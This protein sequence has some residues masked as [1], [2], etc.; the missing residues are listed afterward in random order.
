V[1]CELCDVV[2]EAYEATG[3]RPELV[4]GAPLDQLERPNSTKPGWLAYRMAAQLL[5]Y[6]LYMA[7]T[8]A[9]R[10]ALH[11]EWGRWMT[12]LLQLETDAG[13]VKDRPRQNFYLAPLLKHLTKTYGPLP[14]VN[15][16]RDAWFLK[17][18]G[19]A[20]LRSAEESRIM[21]SIPA[22]RSGRCGRPDESAT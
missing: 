6:T 12:Y 4:F 16:T 17:M 21:R 8:R 1:A 20:R 5:G 3:D 19:R 10:D 2:I 11:H 13:R 14:G 9:E 18:S 22:P 7:D 15:E